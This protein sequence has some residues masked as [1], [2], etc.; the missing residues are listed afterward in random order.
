MAA[1]LLFAPELIL[2]QGKE[3]FSKGLSA[4]DEKT[5]DSGFARA[6]P[7]IVLKQVI[8]FLLGFVGLL[9]VLA[10]IIAGARLI[11]GTGNEQQAEAA[12]KIIFWVVLGLVVVIFAWVIINLVFTQLAGE[13]ST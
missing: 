5:T 9:A 6:E 8:N 4:L 12:K 2:A 1:V 10:I 7:V 11:V 3:S 13:Q